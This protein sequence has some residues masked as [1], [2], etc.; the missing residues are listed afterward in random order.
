MTNTT[1]PARSVNAEMADHI[2]D[3]ELCADYRPLVA[4]RPALAIEYSTRIEAR[5]RHT[6][7]QTYRVWKVRLD[8]TR[9]DDVVEGLSQ[10]E[11]ESLLAEVR[12]DPFVEFCGAKVEHPPAPT[13]KVEAPRRT[14]LQGEIMTTTTHNPITDGGIEPWDSWRDALLEVGAIP[15]P[16]GGEWC[17]RCNTC[18]AEFDQ[19]EDEDECQVESCDGELFASDVVLLERDT[20]A[21]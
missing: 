1:T 11:S 2:N 13:P 17:F 18:G 7:T 15:T 12:R 9:F 3:C 20:D 4:Q 5:H 6:R 8:G 10:S 14:R 16:V 21:A 19:V